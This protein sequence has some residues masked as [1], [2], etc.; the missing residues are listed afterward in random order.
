M[1]HWIHTKMR[2][3]TTVLVVAGVI[4]TVFLVLLVILLAQQGSLSKSQVVGNGGQGED[5]DDCMNSSG[6][7]TYCGSLYNPCY[8]GTFGGGVVGPDGTIIGYVCNGTT[9][10]VCSYNFNDPV[11]TQCAA[12]ANAC[13]DYRVCTITETGAFYSCTWTYASPPAG[14]ASW[15]QCTDA[16]DDGTFQA[17]ECTVN[18]PGAPVPACPRATASASPAPSSPSA[19]PAAS[20]SS[21]SFPP[22]FPTNL[23]PIGGPR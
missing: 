13:G 21:S 23:P 1:L 22:P 10:W 2:S 9:G 5:F 14:Y 11:P 18:P 4:G 8:S 7:V 17:S 3:R 15:V 12:P 6:D 20:P 16:N 19:S